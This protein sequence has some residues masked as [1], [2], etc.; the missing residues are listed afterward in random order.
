MTLVLS[1]NLFGKVFNDSWCEL[2]GKLIKY[3]FSMWHD[4]CMSDP[5]AIK[6]TKHRWFTIIIHVIIYFF[7]IVLQPKPQQSQ[8]LLWF[9][10]VL[11]L[12]V[13]VKF[14]IV[15]SITTKCLQLPDV[16]N[17]E[18][19]IVGSVTS[20]SRHISQFTLDFMPMMC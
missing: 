5:V 12:C 10:T 2:V 9:W 1:N 14:S 20:A 19:C 7:K 13:C 15:G 18:F 3:I 16:M 17:C 4:D 8:W 6:Q 11:L